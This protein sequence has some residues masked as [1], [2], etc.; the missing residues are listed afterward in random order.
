MVAFRSTYHPYLG[1]L[2][3]EGAVA[4]SPAVTA[5]GAQVLSSTGVGAAV[6][7]KGAGSGYASA[8]PRSRSWMLILF[9]TVLVPLAAAVLWRMGS[10]SRAARRAEGSGVG[11]RRNLL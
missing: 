1:R 2:A 3:A 4:P 6:G 9:P 7:G 11:E 10:A 5:G 8:V